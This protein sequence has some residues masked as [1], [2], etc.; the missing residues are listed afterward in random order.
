MR[1]ILAQPRAQRRLGVAD[2]ARVPLGHRQP[3]VTPAEAHGGVHIAGLRR[4]PDAKL[5]ELAPDGVPRLDRQA[6][7]DGR[8]VLRDIG[9]GREHRREDQRTGCCQ[10]APDEPPYDRPHR[11][12]SIAPGTRYPGELRLR[13]TLAIVTS[14]GRAAIARLLLLALPFHALTAIYLDL[15]GPAHFHVHDEAGANDHG[16]PHEHGGVEHHRHATVD[17]SVVPVEDDALDSHELAEDISSG[18]SATMCAALVSA[19]APLHVART[20]SGIV[21][22]PAY[23]LKTRFP[24]RLERPP[25]LLRV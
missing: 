12:R 6:L 24:G 11:R 1:R 2:E 21:A 9:R 20:A 18:W 13:R 10:R 5:A 7:E 15:R 23:L 8:V 4:E 22:G 14:S 19:A 3:E 25:R 17:Q 16:Y